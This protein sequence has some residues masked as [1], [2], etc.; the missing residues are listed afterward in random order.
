MVIQASFTGFFRLIIIFI[1]IYIVVTTITR[2]VFPILLRHYMQ[3]FSNRFNAD[4]P[5]LF[6]QQDKQEGEVKIKHKPDAHVSRKPA[7][8]DEY[9][10][11]E[12]IKEKKQDKQPL[13]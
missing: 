9:I 10:D 12:E 7:S 13:E 8:D 5:D 1:L 4:N 6:Q 2:Y 11:Y 3:N